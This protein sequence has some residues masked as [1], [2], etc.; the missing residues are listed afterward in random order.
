MRS[1]QDCWLAARRS[2]E[3]RTLLVAMEQPADQGLSALGRKVNELSD[4]VCPG[5]FMGM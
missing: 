5:V 2:G 4:Y 3:G 1:S